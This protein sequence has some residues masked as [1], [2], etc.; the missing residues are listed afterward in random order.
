[1]PGKVDAIELQTIPN[2]DAQAAIEIQT[3]HDWKAYADTKYDSPVFNRLV[4]WP[5]YYYIRWKL[6]AVFHIQLIF[7]IVV[8]EVVHV[9]FFLS[10]V[11]FYQI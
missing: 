6:L 5:T 2:Q 8:G 3:P 11:N 9:H 7:G 4:P 10:D 1:M